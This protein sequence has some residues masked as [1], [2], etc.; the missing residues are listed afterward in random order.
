MAATKSP[1]RP[2]TLIFVV[3]TSYEVHG[4]V[5]ESTPRVTVSPRLAQWAGF[6]TYRDDL[7]QTWSTSEVARMSD[8]RTAVR[9][10]YEQAK[11]RREDE[12]KR[13][14]EFVEGR[15][16]TYKAFIV[17]YPEASVSLGAE[18][19]FAATLHSITC[20]LMNE[21]EH[22]TKNAARWERIATTF[23]AMLA[24]FPVNAA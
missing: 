11:V 16:A 4:E 18:N 7:G 13:S 6:E 20:E 21:K 14:A 1:K 10:A 22:E 9:D 19:K 8:Y 24:S 12:A 2:A 15:T 5:N 3:T 17:A 23:E